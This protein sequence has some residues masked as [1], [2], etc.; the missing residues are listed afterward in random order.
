MRAKRVLLT[1][2]AGRL[3]TALRSR[4]RGRVDLLRVSDIEPMEP[5][6]PG[7][8]VVPCDL[9]DYAG[10]KAL[11][12]GVDAIVHLGAQPREAAWPLLIER[13]IAGTVNVYEGARKAR[14]DRVLFASSIT[15]VG[16]YRVN[17]QLDHATPP[18][19]DGRYG[20]TKAFGETLAM[21]YAYKH[22]I[23]GF[24]MRLGAF[25]P[26]PTDSSLLPIWL[27]HD[28]LAR[29]VMVGLTADYR[30]EIVYGLS[31]SSRSSVDNSN[32]FRLG[33]QPQDDADDYIDG[34]TMHPPATPVDAAFHGA[35]ASMLFSG[36]IDW[37]P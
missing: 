3:G 18:R 9:G 21:L 20:V 33:Y 31:R 2:A 14:V 12:R 24:V 29:L 13:N 15:A 19:P 22:A 28:D 4:L 35:F 7:E 34:V 17:V 16:F 1:G 10:V 23:R 6:G 27:S 30:F 26:K 37:V 8:E 32:A 36:D 5:A 25:R 11:C